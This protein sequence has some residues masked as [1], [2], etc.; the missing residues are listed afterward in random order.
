MRRCLF[1]NQ[2]ESINREHVISSWIGELVLELRLTSEWWAR[3]L[4]NTAQ[5]Q[6]VRMIAADENAPEQLAVEAYGGV[7]FDRTVRAVCERCN[8]GWMSRLENSVRPFLAAMLAL[9]PRTLGRQEQKALATWAE[10]R[11]RRRSRITGRS[12][13]RS[14]PRRTER[15]GARVRCQC[16]DELQ[17]SIVGGVASHVLHNPA[18]VLELDARAAA[19]VAGSGRQQRSEPTQADDH[20]LSLLPLR[21]VDRPLPGRHPRAHRDPVD[22]RALEA[23]RRDA[24]PAEHADLDRRGS[25]PCG[26]RPR[27]VRGD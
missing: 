8:S 17:T 10:R 27:P 16:G 14:G 11:R 24:R 9:E 5:D 21:Q 18:R 15:R 19:R 1:C 3:R 20:A 4:A 25:A 26:P 6:Q 13:P 12:V 23:L 7:L 22:R 2:T